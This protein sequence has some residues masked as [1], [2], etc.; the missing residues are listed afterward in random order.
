MK[1]TASVDTTI[2]V[3]TA[4]VGPGPE[5]R[6]GNAPTTSTARVPSASGMAHRRPRAIPA[7]A[8]AVRT[9]RAGTRNASAL[10][11]SPGSAE[12]KIAGPSVG[13]LQSLLTAAGFP[14]E[15][16]GELGPQT[17]AQVRAF[18]AARGLEADGVVGPATWRALTGA[19][20]QPG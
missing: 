16:D 8:N 5:P 18:Q 13:R 14:C 12:A 6:P 3:I 9:P 17:E 15:S 11:P 20:D 7:A 2:T 1:T 10:S 4:A 19:G